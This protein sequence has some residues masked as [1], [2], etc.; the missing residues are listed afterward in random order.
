MKQKKKEKLSQGN[1]STNGICSILII[2]LRQCI[3]TFWNMAMMMQS[4]E[5]DIAEQIETGRVD[6]MEIL[7]RCNRMFRGEIE[8]K[9]K[10]KKKGK[11]RRE[12]RA[13][14]GVSGGVPFQGAERTGARGRIYI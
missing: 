11:K 7:E 3:T 4:K 13:S 1:N 8:K 9:K 5:M 12:R 6:E 14:D 2:E 10:K